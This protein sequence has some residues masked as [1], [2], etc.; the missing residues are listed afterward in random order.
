MN[1]VFSGVA[2]S[3]VPVLTLARF[4]GEPFAN[5]SPKG[6]PKIINSGAYLLPNGDGKR[7]VKG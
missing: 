4:R 6:P 2:G 1:M 3:G 5:G 7:T